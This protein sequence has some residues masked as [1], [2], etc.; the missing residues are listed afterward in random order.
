MLENYSVLR[1]RPSQKEKEIG[2]HE[3]EK[4][5]SLSNSSVKQR[6]TGMLFVQVGVV[7]CDGNAIAN[8]SCKCTV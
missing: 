1:I 5:V 2:S 8:L 4:L 7:I 3:V 6:K